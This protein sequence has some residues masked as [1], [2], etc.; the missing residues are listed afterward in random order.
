MRKGQILTELKR[1]TSF[2][3][4]LDLL[5]TGIH[6]ISLY[7]G[8][9]SYLSKPKVHS[10][11]KVRISNRILHMYANIH[12]GC[13]IADFSWFPISFGQD[14]R[15][16]QAN[17]KEQPFKWHEIEAEKRSS[18]FDSNEIPDLIPLFYHL[19]SK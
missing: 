16:V 18:R 9:P 12:G 2:L 6:Y 7:L 8:F 10:Q 13:S 1:L 19:Q 3:R 14:L 11:T 4:T 15:F 5:K 17:E